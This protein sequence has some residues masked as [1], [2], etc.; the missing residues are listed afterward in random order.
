MY[1]S[2]CGKEM[3][4][5][6]KFCNHCGLPAG[7][8][9]VVNVVPS[10]MP[11]KKTKWGC[12]I[13]IGLFFVFFVMPAIVSTSQVAQKNGNDSYNKSEE[14]KVQVEST[15]VAVPDNPKFSG[16]CGIQ[17]SAHMSSD[18]INHPCL[19]VSLRN[20][21]MKDI[22]AIKFHA[23]PYDVYGEEIDNFIF[24]QKSLYTDDMIPAGKSKTITFGPFILQNIKKV[25]LYVYSVYYE[26]VTEWGDKDAS[27]SEIIKR[28]KTIEAT[29]EK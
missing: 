3:S 7:A 13:G 6:Q 24:S 19:S 11:K 20:T 4:G 27:E 5:Q 14:Q 9:P 15:R 23:I 2:K 25:K 21:S 18:I 22:A 26:D 12:I 17:A 16:D 29:F 10:E 28:G 1:C 8:V